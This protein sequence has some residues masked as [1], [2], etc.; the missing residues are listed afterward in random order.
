MIAAELAL[1]MPGSASSSS[2]LA[3]LMS[4]RSAFGAG[5]IFDSLAGFGAGAIIL[6]SDLAAGC[7]VWAIDGVAV[8]RPTV[9]AVARSEASV[10]WRMRNVPPRTVQVTL[11]R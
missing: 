3:L 6:L 8:R 4:S 10:K 7:A 5:A 2:A 9:S 1:P 11:W